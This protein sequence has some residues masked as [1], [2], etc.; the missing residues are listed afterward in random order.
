MGR[1][2]PVSVRDHRQPTRSRL[3]RDVNHDAS[4]PV[5]GR[6]TLGHAGA[7]ADTA[8]GH[9]GHELSERLR[10]SQVV[11]RLPSP[12]AGVGLW[13]SSG[14]PRQ[15]DDPAKEGPSKEEIQDPDGM[16]LR[17]A[18]VACQDGGEEIRD[19]E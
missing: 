1:E 16:S 10:A 17:V 6:T 3:I 15:R 13:D 8:G 2:Q 11:L 7:L 14:C 19:G 5:T 9:Q 4:D 18:P 12:R